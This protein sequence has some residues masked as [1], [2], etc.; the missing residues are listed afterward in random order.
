MNFISTV[1]CSIPHPTQRFPSINPTY[2]TTV[3]R[4]SEMAFLVLT[5]PESLFYDSKLNKKKKHSL[6]I[7][8]V[9]LFPCTSSFPTNRAITW[10]HP[11]VGRFE[12]A[13]FI[14]GCSRRVPAP[15]FAVWSVGY[16]A[17]VRC[18]NKS[19]NVCLLYPLQEY[20]HT[21][22]L[23]TGNA[24]ENIQIISLEVDVIHRAVVAGRRSILGLSKILG[25]D[26]CSS[27]QYHQESLHPDWTQEYILYKSYIGSPLSNSWP[28][29][30]TLCT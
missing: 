2:S 9:M 5:A 3:L 13:A 8:F 21:T 17:N 27:S 30:K 1:R 4:P 24:W 16:V 14:I 25:K 15:E 10:M 28:M 7:R 22:L 19:N 29:Q 18:N 12:V 23:P 11:F 20:W 26:C 6:N